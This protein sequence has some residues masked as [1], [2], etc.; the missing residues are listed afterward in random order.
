[1]AP[2]TPTLYR[3]ALLTPAD[4]AE[5]ARV[6]IDTIYRLIERGDLEAIH[7]GRLLRIEPAAFNSYLERAGR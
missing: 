3:A 7:V 6:S 5:L 2:Q 4:A 1:M